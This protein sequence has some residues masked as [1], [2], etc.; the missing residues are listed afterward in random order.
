M[1]VP[2]VKQ[3][4][5]SAQ[6][7]NGMIDQL[8]W[9][10]KEKDV[11]VTLVD[12]NA[13]LRHVS[14]RLEHMFVARGVRLDIQPD[15]P[16]ALGQE[17]WIEEIFANLL[18]NAIKY[19]GS[20]PDPFVRVTGK[21]EGDYCRYEIEDNG[22][23]IEEEHLKSVF[24]MFARLIRRSRGARDWLEHCFASGAALGW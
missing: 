4:M 15:M 14:L 13:V 21:C 16:F 17:A 5:D 24:Q 2:D 9:L 19:M 18:N 12:I 11:P 1:G 10:A 8:L 6:H 22:I 20:D 7:M 3:I 23:G